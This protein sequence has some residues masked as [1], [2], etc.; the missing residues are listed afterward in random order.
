MTAVGLLFSSNDDPNDN[1]AG[2]MAGYVTYV[3]GTISSD[4][5]NYNSCQT[6]IHM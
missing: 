5:N 4:N 1:G 6:N 3:E 2:F